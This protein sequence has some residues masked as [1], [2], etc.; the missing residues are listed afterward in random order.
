MRATWDGAHLP[1]GVQIVLG[2]GAQGRVHLR[3]PASLA[4]QFDAMRD[5]S[6]HTL[7]L[8]DD[9]GDLVARATV[10]IED[11][12]LVATT[13][14]SS[15]AAFVEAHGQAQGAMPGAGFTADATAIS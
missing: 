3:G 14:E 6:S 2:Y 8:Y 5:G 10:Q 12:Q 7:E 9:A 13:G 4:A 15:A 11:V 1:S